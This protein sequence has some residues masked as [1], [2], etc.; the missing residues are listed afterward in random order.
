MKYVPA[1]GLV[2]A[3]VASTAAST[4]IDVAY[5]QE[6]LPPVTIDVPK[7]RVSRH[8]QPADA[9]KTAPRSNKKRTA[10]QPA[11]PA[12]PSAQDGAGATPSVQ[13]GAG[14]ASGIH[15]AA[16]NPQ[17]KSDT[18]NLG[19]LGNRSLQN[20]PASVTVIPQ[21]LID[22]LQTKTVNETLRF[23][24]SVQIRNQQGYEV[25]RP[26]S[27]G[28]QGSV[29]QNTRLDGLSI[30]GTTAIAT[31][32]LSSIQVLNGL[33]GSLYGPAVPAGVFNYTLKR[34]TDIPFLTYRQSFDSSS[35]FT[36]YIDAGGRTPDGAVGIGS[37]SFMARARAGFRKATS[38]A[39]WRAERWIFM[40]ATVP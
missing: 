4:T 29:V 40:S 11:A 27:R 21:D 24:P 20:T 2:L 18:F 12:A 38:I 1:A 7:P 8:T 15:N 5:A 19:P 37:T 9:P 6:T 30:V 32:N 31:E 10:R 13:T 17:Y 23:L 34:P 14:A 22:N 25:S 35:V 26:Q 28:F 3:S 36:E 16:T 33:A 39:R